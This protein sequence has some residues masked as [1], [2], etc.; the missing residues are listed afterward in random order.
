MVAATQEGTLS[1]LGRVMTQW[2][3]LPERDAE[4]IQSRAKAAGTGFVEQLILGKKLKETAIKEFAATTLC[5]TLL[6]LAALDAEQARRE[7]I[8]DLRQSG[9]LKVRQG[10][11]S[12]E[13]VDACTNE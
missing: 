10:V 11:T 12:L 7:C 9:L 5:L 1:G 3:P 4:A 6:D 8:R 2:G 13:E